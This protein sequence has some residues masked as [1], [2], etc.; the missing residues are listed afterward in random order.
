LVVVKG[1]DVV[2]AVLEPAVEAGTIAWKPVL[3]VRLEPVVEDDI[4]VLVVPPD[5]GS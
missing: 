4:G 3:V 5:S 1:D 2:T